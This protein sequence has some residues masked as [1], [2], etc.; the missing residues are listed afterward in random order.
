MA[1][2]WHPTQGSEAT[3]HELEAIACVLEGRHGVLAADV[4]EFFATAHVMA[5]DAGRSRAW[6]KVATLVRVR[7]LR[8]TGQGEARA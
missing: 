2:G 4:A 3:R 5:R 8:R 7:E 6:S 1:T